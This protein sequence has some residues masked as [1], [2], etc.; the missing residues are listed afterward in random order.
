VK[1]A[2]PWHETMYDLDFARTTIGS[3][4]FRDLAKKEA[5]FLVSVLG[6]TPGDHVLDVPCGTGRHSAVLAKHRLKVTGIDINLSCLKLAK[7]ACRGLDV[8]LRKGDMSDLSSCRGKFDAVVNLFTSFGYF[9]T[10]EKNERVLRELVATV[11]PGGQVAIHLINRDWL[12]RVFRPVDWSD[13]TG[14]FT[15]EARKY[16]P[17]TFYNEAQR[18]TI[19]R[20]SGN[21]KTNYHRIRLYSKAEMVALMKRCGLKKVRVFGDFEGSEFKKY[22]SSHPIYLGQK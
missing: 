9:S 2:E 5:A 13:Q 10:D 1:L 22:E 19:D 8:T 17:K 4:R 11:K 3:Q 21:A 12:L 20:R 16:D 15:L 6:L 7:S 14:R 18:I